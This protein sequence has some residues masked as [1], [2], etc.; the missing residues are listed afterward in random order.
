MVLFDFD[1]NLKDR[2]KIKSLA[3]ALNNE[4][5]VNLFYAKLNIKSGKYELAN[6][7]ELMASRPLFDHRKLPGNSQYVHNKIIKRKGKMVK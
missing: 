4:F 6:E 7:L 2:K 3:N 5:N 1:V